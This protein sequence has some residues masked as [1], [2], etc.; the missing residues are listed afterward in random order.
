MSASALAD[1]HP[2]RVIGLM[3][4]SFSAGQAIGSIVAG[5]VA[6]KTGS[7][8]EASLL[9]AAALVFAAALAAE[10]SGSLARR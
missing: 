1:G 4:V 3:T 7:L 9:A 10:S 8:R 5:F 2:Q 6:E